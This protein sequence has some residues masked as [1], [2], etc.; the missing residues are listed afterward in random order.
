MIPVLIPG[1]PA[2]FDL[3]LLLSSFHA[4]DLRHGIE[5]ESALRSLCFGIL[6]IQPDTPTIAGLVAQVHKTKGRATVQTA[7]LDAWAVAT[8]KERLHAASEVIAQTAADAAMAAASIHK[9]DEISM[10]IPLLYEFGWQRGYAVGLNRLFRVPPGDRRLRDFVLRSVE[11]HAALVDGR[12]SAEKDSTG[13]VTVRL[14]GTA[15]LQVDD[16]NEEDTRAVLKAVNGYGRLGAPSQGGLSLIERLSDLPV[17]KEQSLDQTAEYLYRNREAL[18]PLIAR[19][20]TKGL[21][22]LLPDSEEYSRV[23]ANIDAGSAP[24]TAPGALRPTAPTVAQEKVF[25]AR[26]ARGRPSPLPQN[27]D[28]PGASLLEAIQN[29]TRKLRDATADG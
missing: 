15:V 10:L 22:W 13:S 18:Y 28:D 26:R 11:M 4:L 17:P 2:E 5:N 25:S 23:S 24:S 12:L 7:S 20:R 8:L 1:A 14:D 3:P 21:E 9:R 27:L 29:L 16:L 6:G 19:Y